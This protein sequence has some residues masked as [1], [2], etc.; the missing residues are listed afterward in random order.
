MVAI[1]HDKNK[2]EIL[3]RCVN[4]CMNETETKRIDILDILDTHDIHDII[5]RFDV[6]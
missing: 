2:Y 3:I 1:R 4:Q 6:F 5:D